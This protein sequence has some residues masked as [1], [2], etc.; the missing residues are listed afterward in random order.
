MAPV[1]LLRNS[2]SRVRECLTRDRVSVRMSLWSPKCTVLEPAPLVRGTRIGL[3]EN[4]RR[5]GLSC[6]SPCT[7]EGPSSGFEQPGL[8]V[9][10]TARD[11]RTDGYSEIRE[12]DGLE[13]GI[14]GRGPV[15][16]EDDPECERDGTRRLSIAAVERDV[17]IQ[18][19]ADRVPVAG[20]QRFLRERS[21]RRRARPADRHTDGG[22]LLW[23]WW[24][25]F[26]HSGL[27][28]THGHS[29]VPKHR[30]RPQ[31]QKF[32]SALHGRVTGSRTHRCDQGR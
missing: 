11:R 6:R 3:P 25:T 2:T 30:R 9:N 24:P 18:Y 23:P 26:V 1:V 17:E 31:H 7:P 28:R 29:P 21:S 27:R 16:A 32:E 13:Y 19:W 15:S 5:S 4:R 12:P 14:A 8:D 22:S 10:C 20:G